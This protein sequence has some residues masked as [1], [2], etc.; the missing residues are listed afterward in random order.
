MPG[1]EIQDFFHSP[2]LGVESFKGPHN[3]F[4]CIIYHPSI[5]PPLEQVMFG[6]NF[7]VPTNNTHPKFRNTYNKGSVLARYA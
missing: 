1:I 3:Y 5:L 4:L 7:I 6:M 2:V